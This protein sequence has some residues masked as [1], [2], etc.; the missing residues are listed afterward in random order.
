MSIKRKCD[1]RKW[2]SKYLK[3][4]GGMPTQQIIGDIDIEQVQEQ[5]IKRLMSNADRKKQGI[6]IDDGL[7]AVACDKCTTQTV[8]LKMIP[9]DKGNGLEFFY[10]CENCILGK[11]NG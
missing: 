10:F 1:P 7:E 9:M 8:K 2:A 3:D 6:E 5:A 11:N 4:G